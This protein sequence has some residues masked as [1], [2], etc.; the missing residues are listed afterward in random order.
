VQFFATYN[1][2]TRKGDSCDALQL[3]AIRRQ[4]SR[5]GR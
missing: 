2:T 1:I 4:V 5:S 3:E